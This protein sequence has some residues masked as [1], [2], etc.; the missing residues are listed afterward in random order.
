ML[1]EG[2]EPRTSF[3]ATPDSQLCQVSPGLAE[4]LSPL[5]RM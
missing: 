1:D 2:L 4:L 5:L 3:T